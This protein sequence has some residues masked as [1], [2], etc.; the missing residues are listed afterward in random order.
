MAISITFR[1]TAMNLDQ[2]NEVLKQLEA[3]GM[4]KPPGRIYHAC[5]GTGDRLTVFDVWESQEAF[6]AFGETLMPILDSVEV[7]PGIPAIAPVHNIIQ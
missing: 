1:P 5:S 3:A 6:D 2:Y 4:S 7:D